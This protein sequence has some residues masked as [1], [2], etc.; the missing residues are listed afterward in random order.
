MS[1]WRWS[2]FDRRHL[3]SVWNGSL[4]PCQRRASHKLALVDLREGPGHQ[5]WQVSVRRPDRY[6]GGEHVHSP[7]HTSSHMIFSGYPLERLMCSCDCSKMDVFPALYPVGSSP[8]M[9]CL[10]MTRAFWADLPGRAYET[11]GTSG[12]AVT[13]IFQTQG[14]AAECGPAATPHYLAGAGA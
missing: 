3:L 2:A 5:I 7:C 10:L 11:A 12:R 6:N 14:G 4:L 13:A 9:T 1:V 8:P